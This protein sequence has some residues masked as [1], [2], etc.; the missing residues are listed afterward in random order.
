MP[1]QDNFWDDIPGSSIENQYLGQFEQGEDGAYE[2][3]DS[4]TSGPEQTVV[5]R[6]ADEHGDVSGA[7]QPA[8]P[9]PKP[10]AAQASQGTRRPDMMP[11]PFIL[12]N[13]GVP[14]GLPFQPDSGLVAQQNALLQKVLAGPTYGPDYLN[15]L[16][17]QQKEM[18]LN[19]AM[20]GRGNYLQDAASRNVL[21]GGTAL[22]VGR[23]QHDQTT[24][25]LLRSH[26]DIALQTEAANRASLLDALGMSESVMGGRESRALDAARFIELIRQ[27]ENQQANR[28]YEFDAGQEY[29]Y[30][31]LN[32]SLEQQ[33]ALALLNAGRI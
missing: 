19:R 5:T 6:I 3:P 33:F 22:G 24:S 8:A 30:D 32:S 27:F 11:S 23:R 15:K 31:N 16:N 20:Q 13:G 12:P 18:I 28:A 7:S 21:H 1:G 2:K 10:Q 9:K 4:T 14:P 25:E 17:E 26:R 29:D